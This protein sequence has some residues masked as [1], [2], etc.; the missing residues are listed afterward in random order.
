MIA[1]ARQRLRDKWG[2]FTR[3][4]FGCLVR[5]FIARMFHGGGELGADELDVGVGVSVILL[6]MPGTLVS[7][8]MFEKYG[9]L[10]RFLRGQRTFD[11]FSAT[12]PDEYFFLVLSM[13]VTGAA[14]LW[15]WNSIFLDRRD[16]ANLVPLP[17]SARSIFFANALAILVIAALYTIVVNAVSLVFF[18]IAVLGSQNSFSVLLRFAAGHAIAVFSASA[19]SF[20]AVLALVGIPMA[21]LPANVFRRVSLLVRFLIGICLL[22]LLATS[23]TVPDRLKDL[24]V[25]GAHR[26][27]VLPPV[28]FI[29]VARTIWAESD[30]FT[31]LM[32]RA[33][34]YSLAIAAAA[35]LF[36]YALSFRRVFLRTAELTDAGPLPRVRASLLPTTVLHRYTMRASPDR[37][38]YCFVTRTLLRSDAHLQII[39]GFA[40]L[41]LVAAVQNLT[42][43]PKLRTIFTGEQ[44]SLEFVATPFFLSYCLLAGLRLAFEIPADLRS[45]WIFRFWLNP[46][47]EEGRRA[48]KRTLLT[49]SLGW[50]APATFIST[51]ALWD[52]RSALLHTAIFAACT[53]ALTEVLLIRFRKLPFTCSYPPFR[54]SSA[55]VFVGYLFGFIVFSTYLPEF[56]QWSTIDPVLVLWF[57][58]PLGAVLIGIRQYRKQMLDMDKQLIFEETPG[59]GF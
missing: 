30:W 39:L 59:A 48:A 21:L 24:S 14:V 45:N 19:F 54:S 43:A 44:P 58:P 2:A 49:F 42:S 38:C 46:D 53:Y 25:A 31:A 17:I 41:G 55:L 26:L 32:N 28:S 40:A 56:D 5:L 47:G 16:Y 29:G 27:A 6:A 51:L 23:F 15:R 1:R 4:P 52:W 18:P 37:A 9:S 35:A 50:L 8:L 36:A 33:A 57:V 3:E 13:V 11:P 22:V 12:V 7:L 34:W 10:I 20:F